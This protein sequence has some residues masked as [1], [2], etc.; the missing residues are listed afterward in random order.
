MINT[1]GREPLAFRQLALLWLLVLVLAALSFC[2]VYFVWRPALEVLSF[3][4][5][6]DRFVGRLVYM[7]IFVILMG[8]V[9]LSAAFGEPI[10]ERAMRRGRLRDTLVRVG[11]G[12]LAFGAVGLALNALL[13]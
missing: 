5:F 10:L 13:G 2:V 6:T 9:A 11:G 8:V 7:T 1:E 12:L 4:I 3:T